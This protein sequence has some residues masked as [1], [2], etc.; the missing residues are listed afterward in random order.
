MAFPEDL[1]ANLSLLD[2]HPQ[3]VRSLISRFQHEVRFA[4]ALAASRPDVREEWEALILR[5]IGIVA[6]RIAEAGADPSAAVAEA[7]GV[8]APIARAAKEYTIHCV[9]HAHIDMNWMWPWPETVATTNDTFSTVN[10]LMDEFPTFRFSQSQ[11]STY[12]AM[13]EHCPDIFNM[14]KSRVAQGRWEVTANM[15]VEGDKNL[16]SGEILCRHLLYTK[17]YFRERFGIPYDG[18]K[19]DWEPDTF[20][21]AHTLPAILNRA[22]VTR[23]YFCRTGTGPRLFW[24]QAPDGSRVLAFDDAVL[25]YN[26]EITPDLVRLLL[27]FEQATG[28]K[29]YLFVYGVG[30]HGGGPT[31]RDLMAALDM[32]SWPIWPNVRLATTDEFYSIAERAPKELPVVNGELNSV[33]EGCYTSQSNIKRANRASENALYEAEAVALIAAAAAGKPYPID[34]LRLAWRRAMFNQFHDVLPGSGVH[35]TYEYS[36]GLYQEIEAA[37]QMVRTNGLRALAGRVNTASLVGMPP[38]DAPGSAV[39]PGIGGGPGD[40]GITGPITARGAGAVGDEPFLIFNPSTW[41]RSEVVTAK[42]WDKEIPS[43]QLVVRDDAGAVIPAQVVQ[44][45]DYWGHRF[46]TV[47]F[48][49]PNVPALG[50]RTFAIGRAVTPPQPTPGA[51]AHGS[52]VL[53]N[54][55]LRVE[56]E[57]ASGAIVHL[58]DKRTGY[59]YVP[60]GEHLGLLQLHRE[61][62]HGMTAW[63]I[64]QVVHVA[65]FVDGGTL[66]VV[67]SGPWRAA[68]RSRRVHG[69]SQFVLEIALTAGSPQVEFTLDVDWLERGSPTAGVPMLKAAFPVAVDSPQ[70]T[71]EIPFGTIKRPANGR[72]VPSLTWA[73]I[74]GRPSGNGEGVPPVVGLTLLNDS[75][76]GHSAMANVLNLTLLRSSYDPDPLPELGHHTIRFAVAPHVGALNPGDAIR[77][78]QAFN[79]PFSVVGTD[80]HDGNLPLSGGYAEV[81]TPNTVLACLKRAEDS[82]ALVVRLYEVE[83]KTTE[84]RLRLHGSLAAP[85]SPAVET[86]LLEQPLVNSTAR[87]DGDTLAVTVPAYG[88]ATVRV[89]RQAV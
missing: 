19:I 44:R 53:E 60:K 33:F 6:A 54:E 26:G 18:V 65:S 73:D 76:Y 31:R 86:D 85:G 52:G 24:W 40:P 74:S 84:A 55:L 68:L 57:Q 83:G 59:D 16:A 11:A 62:P 13:E 43:H 69:D 27:E 3:R 10:R 32:D 15:W 88:I 21:H 22:G 78:G 35:A 45:G 61:A 50:Y 77:A 7:E 37:T 5:A 38:A 79:H 8:L 63:E 49:A 46:I 66:E 72:E 4:A 36:Q 30:D 70:P 39:G 71:Y 81:L 20:G 34:S 25:W 29:D 87:M 28:L 41:P 42:V 75:K 12:A 56:V 1:A 67:H 82:Q 58:I 89:E 17:R 47:A 14:I 23:Y 64:G 2:A 9:G 51:T 48:P 80:A